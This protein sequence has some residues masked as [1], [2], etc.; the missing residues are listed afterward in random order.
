MAMTEA[1]GYITDADDVEDVAQE[2]MLRLW[3]RRA[4]IHS[5][6]KM[7]RSYVATMTRNICKDRQKVKRRHLILRL[8]W[9]TKEDDEEEYEI[10]TYET[11]QKR[12]EA[13]EVALAYRQALEKL[14]YNWRK[15][16]VMRGE[17]EMSYTEIAQIL[18]T[19]ESSV[20]GTIS[21]AKKKILELIKQ[22]L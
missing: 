17:D 10:P 20:R 4:E 14:P 13:D 22:E 7:L 1:H 9:M 15:I 16:L 2:V 8:L 6:S 12:M 21:K 3:E 18:G 5:E 19:T 11:P